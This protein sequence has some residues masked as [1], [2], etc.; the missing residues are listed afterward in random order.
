VTNILPAAPPAGS[1]QA[2][3]SSRGLAARVAAD[4]LCLVATPTLA[5][6]AL[7]TALGGGEPNILCAATQHASP[8]SGMVPMYLMMSAFHSAP[9]LRLICGRYGDQGTAKTTLPSASNLV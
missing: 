6:M 4:W 1:K 5:G 3:G 8:I 7:L 2:L 9:W